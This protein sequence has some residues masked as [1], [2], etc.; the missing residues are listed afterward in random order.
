MKWAS[1]VWQ[2][3]TRYDRKDIARELEKRALGRSASGSTRPGNGSMYDQDCLRWFVARMKMEHPMKFLS[4]FMILW[5]AGALS[6][7]PPDIINTELK[8]A[9][10]EAYSRYV[11]AT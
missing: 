10:V 4:A 9:T 3:R 5:A 2:H 6:A 8:Q 1:T 11:E 7:S